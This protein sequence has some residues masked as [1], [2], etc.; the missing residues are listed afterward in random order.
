VEARRHSEKSRGVVGDPPGRNEGKT[1][2]EKLK[3]LKE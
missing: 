3:E 2:A 1:A